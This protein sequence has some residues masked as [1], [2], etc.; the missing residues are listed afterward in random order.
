MNRET[1]AYVL[2]A[3]MVLAALL[4]ALYARHHSRA[5]S[6]LRQRRREELAHDKAMAEKAGF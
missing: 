3:C 4:I 6:Y 2:L 5:R 1:I